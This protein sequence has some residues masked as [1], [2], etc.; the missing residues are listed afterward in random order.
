[1]YKKHKI[2]LVRKL[3]GCDLKYQSLFF[4]IFLGK[5]NEFFKCFKVQ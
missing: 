1:M 5:C 3:K 4:K 2:L